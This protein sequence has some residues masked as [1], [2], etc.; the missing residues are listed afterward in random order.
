MIYAS[1]CSS[2]PNAARGL[3]SRS[4]LKKGLGKGQL[5]PSLRQTGLRSGWRLSGDLAGLVSPRR[6]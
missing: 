4:R 6:L 2:P 3:R 5:D 1:R